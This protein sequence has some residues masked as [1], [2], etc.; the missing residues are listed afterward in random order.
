[1]SKDDQKIIV[2]KRDILFS[3]GDFQGFKWDVDRSYEQ[4][5][6]SNMEVMRRRDAENNPDF[7]QPIGYALAIHNGKKIIA[8]QRS[9][10]GGE[11]R[12]HEKWAWG[13]GGHVEPPDG[14][15]VN[16]LRASVIR[17][18]WDEE[19]EFPGGALFKGP[20]LVGYINDDSNDVGKVH[21][22]LLYAFELYSDRVGAKDPEI[23]KVQLFSLGELERMCAN[24]QF[25]VE[26]WSRIALE[27]L[28]QYKRFSKYSK[29]E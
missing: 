27:P 8:Y 25:D 12:L 17:E 5:I 1:M 7:K 16:P 10:Q 24:P 19:L 29:L 20:K 6:L 2:V 18:V 9:S 3:D 23:A 4:R 26:T 28:K 11:Q 13:F 14:N 22:G 15:C 21:F